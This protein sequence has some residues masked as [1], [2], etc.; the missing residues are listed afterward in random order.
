M[1]TAVRRA[2]VVAETCAQLMK[3]K[4]HRRI[5]PHPPFVVFDMT[6]V[7]ARA[8]GFLTAIFFCALLAL[9][10]GAP[11]LTKARSGRTI[12][13][14][15]PH[16]APIVTNTN[17]NGPG[18]LR[19]A[20][21]DAQDGDTISFDISSPALSRIASS[22]VAIALS[23]GELVINNNITVSGPGANMLEITRDNAASPFRIFKINAGHTVTIRGLTISN[24]AAAA[25]GGIYN[26]HGFLTVDRCAL[27]G[28]SASGPAYGGGGIYN[29]GTNSGNATLLITHS[30]LRGNSAPNGFGGG[31]ASGGFN[32]GNATVH[33]VNSTLSGNSA[34]LGGGGAIDQDGSSGGTASLM[35]ASS[36]L[37]DNSGAAGIYSVLSSVKIGNSILKTGGS[38][39]NI[40]S[41]GGVV[42]SAG[43]NLSNDIARGFLTSGSD[44]AGTD[45]M[46]GPL[47]DNGGPTFTYAPLVNSPAIDQGKSDVIPA[48]TAVS[49]QR[50]S[51]RPINDPGVFNAPGGDGSDIGAVE[52]T[53]GPH[54]SSAASWKNHGGA[55]DFGINLPLAE[56]GIEC[57]SG[58]PGDEYKIILNFAQPV[59]FSGAQVISGIGQISA[60]NLMTNKAAPIR[61]SA[62]A[63]TQIALNLTGVTNAQIITIALFDVDDGSTHN[64]VGIRLGVLVGDTTGNGTVNASDVSLVKVQ[65]G[66]PV[67][68]DNFHA[69]I[70]TNGAIN[71]SDVSAIKLNS[72]T[73]L[74]R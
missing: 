3:T 30:L 14:A 66:Q 58:G 21:V 28:N 74:V 11:A 40:I 68:A 67:G 29:D 24:G 15:S 32:G 53:G 61:N 20:V 27:T 8:G 17:D 50:G 56:V 63:A 51:V 49:D 36:T 69:D 31:V 22:A 4:N 55:G 33:V 45:P 37:G 42:T 60:T 2:E 71:A 54:L 43:Y 72:G 59:S 38:E 73:G 25:G 5:T 41:N 10:L 52:L 62:S 9:P 70:I 13:T 23:G 57:R 34:S 16:E 18:S 19:Q 6:K 46:L 48:L 65:S 39:P 44:Q 7:A 26:D 12:T 35:I 64:D 1:E 47:K